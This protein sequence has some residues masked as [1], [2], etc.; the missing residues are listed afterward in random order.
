M[1]KI[2]A[3]FVIVLNACVIM[4][5]CIFSG[6]NIFV[7]FP[8]GE[9]VSHMFFQYIYVNPYIAILSILIQCFGIV[10]FDMIFFHYYIVC[11]GNKMC[12]II[13]KVIY[14]LICIIRYL[15]MM[16]C[17]FPIGLGKLHIVDI[18][19]FG[20]S[21]GI[22]GFLYYSISLIFPILSTMSVREYKLRKK[23]NRLPTSSS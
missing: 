10:M 3:N 4:L 14:I 6:Y 11:A 2:I 19:G 5:A 13:L 21:G 18:A 17:N 23:D 9:D 15:V 12:K 22:L 16:I 20:V 8:T 7:S 1:R